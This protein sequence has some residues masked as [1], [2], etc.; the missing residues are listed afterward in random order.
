MGN[1]LTG[2]ILGFREGLEAFLM[3]AILL[4]FMQRSARP[5][6][7]K[8]V[9]LGSLMGVFIFFVFGGYSFLCGRGN[10]EA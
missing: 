6:L 10:T 5:E 9:W 3:V 1:M 8:N 2:I 7:R 4:R